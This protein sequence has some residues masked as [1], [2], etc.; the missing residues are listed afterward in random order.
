MM[1]GL[2]VTIQLPEQVFNLSDPTALNNRDERRL[3]FPTLTT[4][5]PTGS[6]FC[7]NK[8]LLDL[9]DTFQ[10]QSIYVWRQGRLTE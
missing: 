1:N 7:Q 5:C 10:L 4:H 3:L 2:H 6:S 9:V 8:L